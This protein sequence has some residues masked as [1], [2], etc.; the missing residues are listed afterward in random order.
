ME[1]QF[2]DRWQ[3]HT[4]SRAERNVEVRYQWD[5]VDG[6]MDWF[7]QISHLIIQNPS[8]RSLAPGHTRGEDVDAFVL[9]Q[10]KNIVSYKH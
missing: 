5:T 8:N 3:S 9:A 1:R 4:L 10:V 7:R 6:Y 2:W